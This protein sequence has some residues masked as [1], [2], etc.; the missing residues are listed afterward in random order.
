MMRHSYQRHMMMP[1]QPTANFVVVETDFTFGFFVNDFDGP[2]HTANTY[3]FDQG[4]VNGSIAKVELDHQRII[5]IS[6]DNQPD[7]WTWQASSRLNNSQEG[8]ISY[9]RTLA[10]FF[11]RISRPTIRWN[12]SYQGINKHSV[13]FRMAQAGRM[14]FMPFPFRDIDPVYFAKPGS[15]I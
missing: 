13:V 7:F 9:N 10:A 3:K 1:T 11:D 8:K 12:I 2:T 4:S 5:Q 15:W 6:A 14:S